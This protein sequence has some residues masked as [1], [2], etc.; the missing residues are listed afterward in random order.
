LADDDPVRK[1]LR[2]QSLWFPAG[3]PPEGQRLV[4]AAL[5]REKQAF[6]R[7]RDA[8][9]TS[10]T[11]T[12]ELASVQPDKHL[13]DVWVLRN[14]HC[15]L[16]PFRVFAR[17][18][19]RIRPWEAPEMKRHGRDFLL[20]LAMEAEYED[21]YDNFG[22]EVGSLLNKARDDLRTEVWALF[23]RLPEWRYF[24]RQVLRVAQT[25][26]PR[27][28][29]PRPLSSV[30]P[31]PEQPGEIFSHSDD[32]RNITFHGK[33]YT[34]PQNAAKIIR[35]LHEAHMQ[36][37]PAVPKQRLLTEIEYATEVRSYLRNTGLWGT[38]VIRPRRGMYQLN[39]PP[40]PPASKPKP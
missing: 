31:A 23:R 14:R 17:E 19:R 10:V 7:Q 35:V 6:A 36:S 30:Q 22:R 38:L 16:R 13:F 8:A 24:E 1:P 3:F 5:M 40:L 25:S 4:I 18:A 15:V 28:S 9:F 32:Y 26:P 34:L 37:H 33:K 27:P 12:I 20:Q 39:L 2:N 29:E 21:R 11:G